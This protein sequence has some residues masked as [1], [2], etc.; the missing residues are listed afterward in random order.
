M[1]SKKKNIQPTQ[2]PLKNV[3]NN[4]IKQ[5]KVFEA[6]IVELVSVYRRDCVYLL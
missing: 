6:C 5:K 4:K 1:Q 2:K 3:T